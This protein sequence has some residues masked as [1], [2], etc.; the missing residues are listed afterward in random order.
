[1]C[2]SIYSNKYNMKHLN[3]GLNKFEVDDSIHVKMLIIQKLWKTHWTIQIL[4]QN[5]ELHVFQY[6]IISARCDLWVMV[7]T[8]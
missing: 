5:I 4:L 6:I 8:Y 1:M 3:N 7:L 2:V